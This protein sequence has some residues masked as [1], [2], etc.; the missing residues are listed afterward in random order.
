M[1]KVTTIDIQGV[2]WAIQDQEATE[3]LDKLE[4]KT[5]MKKTRLWENGNSFFEL[6]EISGVKYYN[7]SFQGD[8]YIRKIGELIF[9]IP[10]VEQVQIANRAIVLGD[11]DDYQGRVPVTININKDGTVNAF[12]MFENQISGEHTGIR[13]YGDIFQMVN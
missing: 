11:I 12:A 2:Q 13:L 6:V 10:K 5:T 8:L 7:I 4:E 3:R 9:T 1:E